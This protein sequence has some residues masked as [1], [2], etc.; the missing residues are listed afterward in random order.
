MLTILLA[1]L[2]GFHALS[3]A[4]S[5]LDN[6]R[7]VISSPITIAFDVQKHKVLA[8]EERKT[9]T[10][11]VV[12]EKEIYPEE[13]ETDVEKYICNKWGNTHCLTAIAIFK[14]E[15]GLK[16]DAWNAN[17]GGSSL[18]GTLDVGIAQ[19]N[20]ET[21]RNK[22]ECSL[23]KLTN[24]KSNIDCAYIIWDEQDGTRGNDRGSFAPWVKYQTGEYLAYAQ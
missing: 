15:S 13:V 19:V 6:N 8:V 3:G 24:A 17:G 23:D 22:N 11:I 21:H 5:W 7:V 18:N 1:M 10:P 12:V 2:A 4:F 16:E 20:Y 9:I 14:A